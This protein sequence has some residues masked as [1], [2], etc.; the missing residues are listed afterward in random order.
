MSAINIPVLFNQV[1]VNTVTGLQV[2]STDPYASPKRAI[3]TYPLAE[4]D[5]E[6][7]TSSRY[8]SR[9]I[10]LRCVV[11]RTSKVLMEQ[12]L[13]VLENLFRQREKPLELD[14][15]GGRRIFTATMSNL[16]IFDAN[17]GFCH[18]DVEL[19]CAD[20]FGY[21]LGFT[22]LHSSTGITANFQTFSFNVTGNALQLPRIKV[23]VNSLTDGTNK[24]ITIKDNNRGSTISVLRTWVAGDV[25]A[26][27]SLEG[28]VTVNGDDASYSGGFPEF[29]PGMNYIFYTDEFTARNIRMLVEYKRRYL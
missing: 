14:V 10:L 13:E 25:L 17:G 3:N 11:I 27:D 9:R 4:A 1:D 21:A 29:E 23:T 18:V 2:I 19:I 15:S 12:S 20:P 28:T 22:Q 16:Q 26:I 5:R 24:T 8:R 6:V 7:T